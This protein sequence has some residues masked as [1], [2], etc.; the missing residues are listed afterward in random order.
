MPTFRSSLFFYFWFAEAFYHYYLG[1]YQ[2]F[3]DMIW[4]GFVVLE[5]H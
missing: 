2:R 3:Y 1:S 5:F 4:N